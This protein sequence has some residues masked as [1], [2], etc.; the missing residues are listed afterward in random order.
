MPLIYSKSSK[1]RYLKLHNMSGW[2]FPLHKGTVLLFL[3]LLLFAYVFFNYVLSYLFSWWES[4][5]SDLIWD[6]SSSFSL[7]PLCSKSTHQF[8]LSLVHPEC[9]SPQKVK[10]FTWLEANKNVKTNAMLLFKRP[11]KTFYPDHY[12]MYLD[13]NELVDHLFLHCLVILRF[14]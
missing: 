4:L 13:C 11:S 5:I 7:C 9:Q 14:W 2:W 6:V 12:I 1:A 8:S 3:L 10:A